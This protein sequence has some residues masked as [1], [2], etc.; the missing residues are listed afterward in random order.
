M[1]YNRAFMG[2]LLE[3]ERKGAE[4]GTEEGSDTG[5]RGQK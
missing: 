2:G 4:K 5:L 3:E 1:P